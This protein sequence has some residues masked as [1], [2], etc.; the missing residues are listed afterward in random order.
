LKAEDLSKNKDR[1]PHNNEEE[2]PHTEEPP[3]GNDERSKLDPCR[4]LIEQ[5]L[6]ESSIF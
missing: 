1:P 5:L 6:K 3:K 4:D 2:E